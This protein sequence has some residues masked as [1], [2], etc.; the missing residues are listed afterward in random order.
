M[1]IS[2]FLRPVPF[3]GEEEEEMLSDT[4]SLPDSILCSV[5]VHGSFGITL[6]RGDLPWWSQQWPLGTGG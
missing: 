5:Q 6:T 1:H 3:P 4:F 2:H